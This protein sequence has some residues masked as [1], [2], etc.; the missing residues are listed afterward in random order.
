MMSK[1]EPQIIIIIGVLRVYQL[2]E[3]GGWGVYIIYWEEQ[4][5]SLLYTSYISLTMD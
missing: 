1:I 3:A 5:L 2:M 4:R